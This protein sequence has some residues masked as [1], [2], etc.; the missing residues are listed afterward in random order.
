M[1]SHVWVIVMDRE[2]STIHWRAHQ[3]QN[4]GLILGSYSPKA[5]DVIADTI[6]KS[7]CD[8][9]LAKSIHDS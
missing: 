7:D 4:C 2:T 8:E 6:N 5:A 3:C 9:Y 1:R